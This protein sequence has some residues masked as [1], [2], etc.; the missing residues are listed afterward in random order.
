MNLDPSAFDNGGS[1]SGRL[2][3]RHHGRGETPATDCRLRIQLRVEE[4]RRAD[5][6]ATTAS[7]P[8]TDV[9]TQSYGPTLPVADYPVTSPIL[10]LVWLAVGLIVLRLGLAGYRRLQNGR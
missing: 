10:I 5:A 3:C 4:G 2:N 1:G 9:A 6:R 7:P 8:G